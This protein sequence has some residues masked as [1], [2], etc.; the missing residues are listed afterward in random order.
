MSSCTYRVKWR[1]S[2]LWSRYDLHVVRH[3]IE[4]IRVSIS[5]YVPILHRFSDIARYWSKIVDLNLP[6][7]YLAPPLWV[8]LS[9][10]YRDLWRKKTR[11]P[12]LSYGVICVIMHLSTLVQCRL[13][14]D[15]QTDRQAETRRQQWRQP[16]VRTA[17][18]NT[19]P[20]LVQH[21]PLIRLRRRAIGVYGQ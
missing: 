13:V 17:N 9:E 12:G 18:V 21:A 14:T 6:H 16:I 3:S 2:N 8:T 15:R 1:H 19:L 10:F 7:L 5:N 4:R 20:S 11:V